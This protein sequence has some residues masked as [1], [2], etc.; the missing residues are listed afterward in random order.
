MLEELRNE[1]IHPTLTDNGDI[2]IP[3]GTN[4]TPHM[5][6]RIKNNKRRIVNELA[7][8]QELVIFWLPT[9]EEN[10]R[11]YAKMSKEDRNRVI[12]E[13]ERDKHKPHAPTTPQEYYHQAMRQTLREWAMG[14]GVDLV[15]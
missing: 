14:Y 5:R 2:G 11:G 10:Y 8:E 15:I 13:F 1:G 3:M 12:A 4:L 9:R 6:S 7:Q